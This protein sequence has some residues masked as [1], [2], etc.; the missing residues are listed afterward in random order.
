M[1]R[2]GSVMIDGA[3]SQA[4]VLVLLTLLVDLDTEVGNHTLCYH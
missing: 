1:V 2:G 4:V 3:C